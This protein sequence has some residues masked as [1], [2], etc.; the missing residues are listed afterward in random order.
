V[1]SEIKIAKCRSSLSSLPHF[2]FLIEE[3]A[4][5]LVQK[6][7]GFIRNEKGKQGKITVKNGQCS[8]AG[9]LP[10]EIYRFFSLIKTIGVRPVKLLKSSI[11]WAWSAL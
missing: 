11:K 5:I 3:A 10:F 8:W 2:L 4:S 1:F 7:P 9:G 6:F